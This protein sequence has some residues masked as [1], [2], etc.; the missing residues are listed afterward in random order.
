ML[1][2]IARDHTVHAPRGNDRPKVGLALPNL[3]VPGQLHYLAKR[4]LQ[5]LWVVVLPSLDRCKLA[6][7]LRELA[8]AE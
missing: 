8:L 3:R 5:K 1:G 6:G 2:R 4:L 7:D